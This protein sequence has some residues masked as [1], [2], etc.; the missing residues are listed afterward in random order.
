MCVCV[1]VAQFKFKTMHESKCLEEYAAFNT[2]REKNMVVYTHNTFI[3]VMRILIIWMMYKYL[4][5]RICYDRDEK[6]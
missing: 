2:F 4:I 3:N 6:L 5:E 1:W